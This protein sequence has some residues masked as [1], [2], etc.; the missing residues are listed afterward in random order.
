MKKNETAPLVFAKFSGSGNDFIIIDNRGGQHKD[1]KTLAEQTCRRGL[2]IGADGLLL[3]ENAE[4]PCDFRMR[5]INAD[6]SEAEMCGNGARCIARYAFLSGIVKEKTMTFMTDAGPVA[7]EVL[8]DNTVKVSLDYK[9]EMLLDK[10]IYL[11]E[12]MR[13]VDYIQTGVPHTIVQ[14]D[15][16]DR[17]NVAEAGVEI[18]NYEEFQ[19]QGTNVNFVQQVNH[20]T[21]MIR[22]YERGVE[23]ETLACG[24]GSIAA[25]ISTAIKN[26][27]I[28]P[29]HV[30]TRSGEKLLVY[31]KLTDTGVTDL[32]LSGSA[33]LVYQGETK[34]YI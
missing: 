33:R 26:E 1:P 5:I 34:E 12:G 13:K 24:T 4:K 8:P 11:K 16:V 27:I 32:H 6:G 3:L 22:T 23:A 7:A 30:I 14:V 17:V 10:L 20:N 18:R 21:I 9:V 15:N 29:V 2:S 25:A 31:F 28:P 19:P